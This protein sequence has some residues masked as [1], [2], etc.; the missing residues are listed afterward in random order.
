MYEE[1]QIKSLLN[2]N[3]NIAKTQPN[4]IVHEKRKSNNVT[5]KCMYI[6]RLNVKRAG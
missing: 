4:T 1:K 5:L 3:T 2:C 6:Q